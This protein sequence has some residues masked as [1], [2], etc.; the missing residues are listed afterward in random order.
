MPRA[1]LKAGM[2]PPIAAGFV[3][4]G[5]GALHAGTALAQQQ[6]QAPNGV[7]TGTDLSGPT[8]LP[9]GGGPSPQ[10]DLKDPNAIRGLRL[11][12]SAEQD[13]IL[14][15]NARGVANG[16]A[17]N[18]TANGV[19]VPGAA[20]GKR[21]GDLI[22]RFTPSISA[23]DRTPRLEFGLNYAPSYEK[24]LNATDQ[25]T[26]SNNLTATGNA[27]LWQEHLSLNGTASI[28]RQFINNQGA[29]TPTNQFSRTNQ[30]DV[31]TFTIS[32]TF[33]QH[34][35]DFATGKLQ[36]LLGSTSSGVVAP[37]LENTVQASLTSGNDFGRL[38]WQGSLV[39]S[40]ASQGSTP[41]PGQVI[42][43]VTTPTTS[44]DTTQ[45]T[46]Q[47]STSYALNRTVGLL[48]GFGYETIDN[49]TLGGNIHGPFGNFGVGLTGSRLTLQLLY[50][51]RYGGEFVSAQGAYDVTPRLRLQGSY[52]ESV[53]TT[54]T[55]LINNA[56]GIGLTPS[57][58]FI[59]NAT[60]LPF[61]PASSTFGLNSGLGNAIFRDKVGQLTLTGTYERNVY[62]AQVQRETRDSGAV[63][64]SETDT[65]ISASYDRELSPAT[66]Y[67]LVLGFTAID[68]TS[69]IGTSDNVY[70]ATT[71]FNYKLAESVTAVASYS[72]LYRTSSQQGQT[73][74]VNEL[75]L[76][77]RKDF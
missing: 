27:E 42:N 52:N 15:D 2:R 3:L 13:E 16:G 46:A 59:N 12:F 28:S 32:P 25:D 48:A 7:P 8:V 64:F 26:F 5:L 60:Q 63:G 9:P 1:T 23:F 21:V 51:F 47:L 17:L 20:N 10:F 73:I 45:R 71:G 69:P 30:A 68:Q 76:G 33:T 38:F 34:F 53:Q 74:R 14:T 61:N 66:H 18:A 19:I 67:N 58:G 62:A 56:A 75:L 6:V 35:G 22:S 39:D 43:G 54:Q 65:S 24:F 57:G 72:F 44:A 29:I 40:E 55:S 70:S 50:N 11:Q 36:Y 4:A 49:G 31:E 37:T 77:L 41:N